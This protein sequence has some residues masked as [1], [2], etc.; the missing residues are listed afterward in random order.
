MEDV[1]DP[2]MK[3]ERPSPYSHPP[4][5]GLHHMPPAETSALHNYHQAPP[6]GAQMPPQWN[7][8]PSP[9]HENSDHRHPPP[10]HQQHPHSY[11]PQHYPPP[12]PPGHVVDPSYSRHGSVS[13]STRS[14]PNPQQPQYPPPV[15]GSGP[16][17]QYYQQPPPEYRGRPSY[18]PEG[19]P[20]GTHPPPLHVTTSHEM[21]SGQPQ[22]APPLNHGAPYSGGAP[23]ATPYPWQGYDVY[24]RRKPVRAAQACDPCRQRKAKCDE[25]RPSCTHCKDNQLQCIYRDV[26]PQKAEKQVLAITDELKALSNNVE[27]LMDRWKAQEDRLDRLLEIQEALTARINSGNVGS[28]TPNDNNRNQNSRAG[29]STKQE[30]RVDAT[31]HTIHPTSVALDM[32]PELTGKKEPS[33]NTPTA[34]ANLLSWPVIKQLIPK[35]QTA[36]Y[37]MDT[38]SERGLLR[39]YGCGEGEDRGDGHDGAPSPATSSSSGRYPDEEIAGLSPNGVWGTGQFTTPS[40]SNTSGTSARE[41]CGGLAPN[42][43]LHLDSA[44]VEKYYISYLDNIHKLHPFLDTRVLRKMIHT[45]KRKY[46]WDFLTDAPQ[47]IASGIG[48]KRKRETSGSP[49]SL[50]EYSNPPSTHRVLT[51]SPAHHP[52]EHSVANAI[53]LLVLAL[54]KI[55]AY[56][57]PLPGP[58]TTSSIRT[59]TPHTLYSDLP[60]SASA[61]TSPYTGPT[62]TNGMIINPGPGNPQ[63]KNMDI[64]PGLA[65]FTKA[66]DILGEMPGGVDVSHVQA[67]LLAGLYMGQ[68][69][70]ILPSHWYIGNA[71]K[72]CQIIIQSTPYRERKISEARRNLIN[73]A[74]WSC[75]QLESDILAEVEI[76]A[77]GIVSKEA[78]MWNETPAALTLVDPERGDD[79]QVMQEIHRHYLYQIQLRRTINDALK[80]LYN[81]D[82]SNSKPPE[83]VINILGSNLEEWRK[84]LADWDWDDDDHESTD[85]NVARMRGKYYGAKY[86]IH[87]AALY[88]ALNHAINPPTPASRP[89]Q[90]P[91]AGH[92]SEFSTSPA[93]QNT[94]TGP[95]ISHRKVSDMRPPPMKAYEQLEGWI[96]DASQKCVNAAIRSTTA[97]D[98]VPPR[99][100]ITNVFGTA[101]A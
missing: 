37:V 49:I 47:R 51:R 25:G 71:C 94:Y 45:F 78:S 4:P 96:L 43:G 18:G 3:R 46:S 42:G 67:N 23:P 80:Y 89:S 21:M 59:S 54:G 64:V 40:N 33:S 82:R 36:S 58:V 84:V 53:I 16:E 35:D 86:I 92:G 2:Q 29:Q 31:N 83:T 100:I 68:L 88:W 79:S 27:Q 15:N 60:M 50:D 85:I 11:P 55:C 24:P 13:A 81:E 6:P 1:G 38:E 61:P 10:D 56:K 19:Q 69:A 26:P 48:A 99:L 41:H 52:I 97:F 87:R 72:A 39:L 75:L 7:P 44:I 32:P 77:S 98:K 22:S 12:P 14:P 8:T 66:A 93:I 5:P 62:N 57:D 74:F 95:P 70:R 101:H 73:F 65:Y 9:Y 63:G 28:A 30:Q 91:V 76:P 90:S 34:A 20:N 17:H